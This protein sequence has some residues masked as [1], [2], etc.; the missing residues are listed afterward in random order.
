MRIL[1]KFG[2]DDVVFAEAQHTRHDGGRERD[3]APPGDGQPVALRQEVPAGSGTRR[4]RWRQKVR[5]Y[6]LLLNR[7]KKKNR[8]FYRK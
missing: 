5:I 6:F 8:N 3:K 2:C 7:F 4:C 1:G